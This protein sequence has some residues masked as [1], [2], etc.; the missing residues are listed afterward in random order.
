MTAH[1]T[2]FKA[3][4]LNLLLCGISF[5]PIWSQEK[6]PSAVPVRITVT[7][8]GVTGNLPLAVTRDQ[9]TVQQNRNRAHE[10]SI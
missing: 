9:V 8:S 4:I 3:L 2:R 5:V 10:W 1:S 6:A 7:L